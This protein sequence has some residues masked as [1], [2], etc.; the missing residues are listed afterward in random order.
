MEIKKFQAWVWGCHRPIFFALQP[1]QLSY[2]VL[3]LLHYHV[4][5]IHGMTI[6]GS[7]A[8][9]I[10]AMCIEVIYRQIQ[11]VQLK[12]YCLMCKV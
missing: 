3:L 8:N 10:K 4:L 5:Q 9:N 11:K 12:S 7:Q 2:S 6:E 1:S